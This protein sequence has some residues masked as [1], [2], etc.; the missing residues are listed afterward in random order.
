MTGSHGRMR[1]LEV[2]PRVMSPMQMAEVR[3]APHVVLR[4]GLERP[5]YVRAHLRHGSNTM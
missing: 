5:A 3:E 4:A 1:W 2:M